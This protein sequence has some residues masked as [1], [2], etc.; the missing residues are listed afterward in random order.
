[1]LLSYHAVYNSSRRNVSVV[2]SGGM[3]NLIVWGFAFIGVLA[4]LF[5]LFAVL[6]HPKSKEEIRNR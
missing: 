3:I 5:V 4:T 6:T 2:Y 1:M